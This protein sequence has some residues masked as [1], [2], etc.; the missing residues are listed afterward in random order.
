MFNKNKKQEEQRV[1]ETDLTN[2]ECSFVNRLRFLQK[3]NIEYKVELEKSEN[4]FNF[5]RSMY[6]AYD[7]FWSGNDQLYHRSSGLEQ[8]LSNAFARNKYEELCNFANDILD[9]VQKC[10]HYENIK[11]QYQPLLNNNK[12]EIKELK[13]KLGIQ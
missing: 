2:N 8:E 3:Q 5:A 12:K 9:K 4:K 7:A 1:C 10:K 11:Q 13:Q 6:R